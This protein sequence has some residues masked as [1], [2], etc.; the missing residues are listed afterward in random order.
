MRELTRSNDPVF[1]SYLRAELGAEG[2]EVLVLDS[3]ASSVLQPVNMTALQ[4]VMVTD[5]DYW[6]AWTVV[7]EAEGRIS[8]DTVLGGKVHLLQ[9]KEG[10]RAAIDPVLLAASVPAMPADQVLDIGTGTGAAALS[11]LSR[12]PEAWLTGIDVQPDL[13]ALAE[14]A[15]LRNEIEGRARFT[16]MDVS[17]PNAA[18]RTALFDHV[19]SNPPFLDA[20]NG[21][22]PKDPARALAMV[23]STADLQAWLRFMSARLRDAGTLSIIH[24]RDRAQEIMDLLAS[25]FGAFRRLDLISMNDGRPIK[26]CIVQTTKG[27]APGDLS[28]STLVLHN[29]DGSFTDQ[30]QAVLRDGQALT[31]S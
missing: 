14:R 9:P 24:R 2:I 20:R 27:A 18:M 15:A 25:D 1:L 11:L 12:V 29:A 3:F 30:A 21:Q 23:E 26:R 10:F 16:V 19:M 28:A 13:I 22:M 8:E 31:I 6:R 5:D 17:A 4:R 7:E